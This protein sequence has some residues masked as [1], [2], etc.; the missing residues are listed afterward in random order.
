MKY[1]KYAIVA[2]LYLELHGEQIGVDRLAL[3]AQRV[4]ALHI[5]HVLVVEEPRDVGRRLRLH[6]ELHE[7]A[8]SRLLHTRTLCDSRRHAT[9]GQSIQRG[10]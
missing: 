9:V 7:E 1:V 8:V 5:V 4:L 2:L 6:F 10:E 3:G